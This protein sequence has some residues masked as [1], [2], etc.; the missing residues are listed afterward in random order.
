MTPLDDELRALLRDRAAAVPPSPDP[1][2]GIASRARTLRRRRAATAM[3]GAAA[4]VAAVAVAVPLALNGGGSTAVRVPG[5]SA[6]A[7]A[8]PGALDPQHP[9]AFRGTRD[10]AALRRF[11]SDYGAAH[12]GATVAPLWGEVYEP[13]QRYEAAL[14][15]HSPDGDRY[16]FAVA[17]SAG[18][19][20]EVDAPLPAGTAA[21]ALVVAGDEAPRLVVVAPP[22]ADRVEYAPHGTTWTQLAE[23]AP[24]V[25]VGPA[26]G[27]SAAAYRVLASD[28]SVVAS[29]P[30]TASPDTPAG[31]PT[32]LLTWVHRG[33]P[34]SVSDATVV[35][36]FDQSVAGTGGHYRSLW[37]GESH[38]VRVTI[39]Q[40]WHD[41]DAAAHTVSYDTDG[42]HSELFLGAETPVEPW[43]VA[44]VLARSGTELL[45]LLPRPGAGRVG[46]SASAT[47]PFAD[48]A[49]GRSD[50]TPV[51]LVDRTPGTQDDRV[52]VHRGDDS[53]ILTASVA[54]LTCGAKECG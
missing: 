11:A 54:S 33:S 25:A 14:V 3:A 4:V 12:P 17:S 10:E 36:A 44:A 39:G 42:V 20:F 51:G 21:L 15:A 16:A 43:V 30:V 13:S 23:L 22:D 46:Y 8:A 28:G 48:V 26:T 29:G 1:L 50:L 45:V 37:D 47:A 41:G 34:Q 2:G 31:Q 52:Q 32:N 49:S 40:A 35:A 27:S 53:V 18:T 24:G 9:W 5:G 19:S 6:S 38:G 7:T